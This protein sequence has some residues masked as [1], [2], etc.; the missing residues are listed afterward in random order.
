MKRRKEKDIEN[1]ILEYL[2]MLPGFEAWKV[3]TVGVYDAQRGVYR[4]RHSGS[5]YKGVSDIIGFY[6][7]KTWLIEVKTS[8]RKNRLTDEQKEFL[9]AAN[10]NNQIGIV[11]T[12]V[13]DVKDF[14][15]KGE[16]K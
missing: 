12:S 14:I 10:E 2:A 8:K 7:G 4:Q 16:W 15:E 9:A 6:R 3:D 11:V 5:R 13:D 1:A